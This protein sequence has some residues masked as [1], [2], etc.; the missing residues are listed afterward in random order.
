MMAKS[1]EIEDCGNLAGSGDDPH[2]QDGGMVKR[3][4]ELPPKTLYIHPRGIQ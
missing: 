3:E 1:L 2:S 4:R